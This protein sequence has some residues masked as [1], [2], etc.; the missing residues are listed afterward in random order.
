MFNLLNQ[1]SVVNTTIHNLLKSLSSNYNSANYETLGADLS[2]NTIGNI[3]P[4]NFQ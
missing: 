3:Y 1:S 2:L 4:I